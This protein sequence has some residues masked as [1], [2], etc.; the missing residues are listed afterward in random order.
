MSWKTSERPYSTDIQ[1][2]TTVRVDQS[3]HFYPGAVPARNGV[4]SLAKS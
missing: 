4:S 3:K 2:Y 1:T